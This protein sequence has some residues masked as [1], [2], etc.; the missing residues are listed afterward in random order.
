[1]SLSELTVGVEEEYLVVDANDGALVP[2]GHELLEA[3]RREL[4]EQVESE[5]NL[6]QIEI[7]TPVCR[8]L[9]EVSTS[10]DQLRSGLAR[11]GRPLALAIAAV[12]THPFSSWVDQAIAPAERYRRL[13]RDYQLLAREQVI[14]GCHVHVGI[15]DPDLV[16][17][18]MNRVRPWLPVLLALSANSPYWEGNDTGYASY[19][20]EVWRRWPTCVMPPV[21]RDRSHFDA[22]IAA[23]RDIGAVPDQTFLYWYARPSAHYPTLEFRICDVCTSVEHVTGLAGLIRALAWTA[24]EHAA[25]GLPAVW[26]HKDLLEAATWRAA[27][28]GVEDQLVS[29]QQLRLA[30]AEVVVGE[31]LAHVE[32]GLDRHGDGDRVHRAIGSILSEGNGAILQRREY[33]HSQDLCSVVATIDAAPNE[34]ALTVP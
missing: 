29:P 28:Y 15:E 18:A 10:L 6:C 13:E 33:A 17:E 12:G 26:H 2:R 32:S 31:L 22:L 11:A 3:A 1:M 19:R 27:R 23:M 8:T 9:D 4:G 20:T 14:C 21:L 30:P 5:L 16:I 34:S 24:A 25:N 7:G